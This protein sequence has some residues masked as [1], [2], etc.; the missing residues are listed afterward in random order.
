MKKTYIFTLLLISFFVISNSSNAQNVRLNL[1]SG[2]NF[3]DGIEALG[4]NNNYFKG[5]IKAGYQWGAG[6][7]FIVR[8]TYGVELAYFREDTDFPVDYST[9][10]I[11]NDD[12]LRTFGVGLNFIMLAG[13]KYLPLQS[14]T[15]S[16]YGGLMLGMA[17]INN[18]D[19][20]PGSDA[21]ATKF[22]WGARAGIFINASKSVGLK[23]HAQLLSAVQSI[24]GGLYLG[25]GGVGAGLN[26]ESSM[27][28]FGLG[29]ALVFSFGGSK[30]KMRR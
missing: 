2:Y 10:S 17:I 4:N 16:L 29:G 13:N 18:K 11:L 6:L 26:T 12:S 28:Q 21:S 1:Y 8:P 14:K 23:L 25:T 24:N 27:Y 20:L 15:V 9:N 19:P 30:T 5:T 7:E 22:A 3:D